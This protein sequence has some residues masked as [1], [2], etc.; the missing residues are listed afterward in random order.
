MRVQTTKVL[1]KLIGILAFIFLSACSSFKQYPQTDNPNFTLKIGELYTGGAISSLFSGSYVDLH[2]HIDPAKTSKK[3]KCVMGEDRWYVGSIIE[4]KANASKSIRLPIGQRAYLVVKQVTS[5][6]SGNTKNERVEVMTF[7]LL[8]QKGVQYEFNYKQTET[9]MSRSL[10]GSKSGKN[11][12]MAIREW[13][14][15]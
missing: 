7:D 15:C 5:S 10:T 8:P 3:A 9:A 2:V 1:F 11:K 14:N 13:D 12:Q 4:L 6:W